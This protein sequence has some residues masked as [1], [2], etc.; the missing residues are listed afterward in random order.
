MTSNSN[1]DLVPDKGDAVE[2]ATGGPMPYL[3]QSPDDP[4]KATESQQEEWRTELSRLEY[5]IQTLR[6]VL[7]AKNREAAILKQKLGITPMVEMKQDLQSG[8]QTIKESGAYQKTNAAFRS[9]GD[10]A[11]RK[12]G[13]LRN[14][15]AFKSVEEKVGGAYSSVKRRVTSSKSEG[16]FKEA[17]E[18]DPGSPSSGDGP[19]EILSDRQSS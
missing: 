3:T 18:A 4:S 11:S 14:S 9:F 5:E 17:L 10:F 2:G 15:N 1:E 12:L 13:D 7:I 6:T 19:N 16:N 8:I